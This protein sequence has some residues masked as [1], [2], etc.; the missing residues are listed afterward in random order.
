MFNSSS[1]WSN[2]LWGG[3][4]FSCLMVVLQHDTYEYEI[5]K[6]SIVNIDSPGTSQSSWGELEG[7]GLR[8]WPLRVINRIISPITIKTE[9]IY[10]ELIHLYLV[11]GPQLLYI[12]L[13]NT[14][15]GTPA[16]WHNVWG[17]N[18]QVTNV[19]SMAAG[20]DAL[21]VGRGRRSF[22]QQ[23]TYPLVI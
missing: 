19:Q 16:T 7:S 6:R 11:S 4:S 2:S 14:S 13:F 9:V 10:H 20:L 1:L 22:G 23:L 17:K 21:Q 15:H 3:R 12:Y 8:L 18:F 5:G